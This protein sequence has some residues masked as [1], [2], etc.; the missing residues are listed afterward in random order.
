MRTDR[1]VILEIRGCRE[2]G[3]DWCRDD[4]LPTFLK[5]QYLSGLG[6]G[7]SSAWLK[8]SGAGRML[9]QSDKV[10]AL[11]LPSCA[12]AVSGRL[13]AISVNMG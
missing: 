3:P 4:H 10:R 2:A 1:C 5:T 12:K 11:G 13:A 8:H 9:T 6:N 7:I